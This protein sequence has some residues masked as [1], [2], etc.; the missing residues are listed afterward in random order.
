[1]KE[2]EREA[3]GDRWGGRE[4]KRMGEKSA[5]INTVTRSIKI[6]T[7]GQEHMQKGIA[8]WDTELYTHLKYQVNMNKLLCTGRTIFATEVIA[9]YV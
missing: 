6:V 8:E 5:I 1:M 7:L 3:E 4:G 2:K 9:F